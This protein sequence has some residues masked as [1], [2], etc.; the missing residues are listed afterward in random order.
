MTF[1][2]SSYI[3]TSQIISAFFALFA[4]IDPIGSIPLYIKY[5]KKIGTV[6]A[7]KITLFVAIIMISFLFTGSYIL[8]AFGISFQDFAVAG[9]LILLIL[10]LEMV[11][12]IEI[13]KIDITTLKNAFLTPVAFP[14]IVGPGVLTTL[15]TLQA[16]Y[17]LINILIALC[18]NILILYLILHYLTHIETKL[19]KT[20]IITILHKVMGIIL[21]AIAIKLFKIH[22]FQ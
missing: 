17:H 9:G 5:K 2:L 4:V 1:P 3:N 6:N 20:G 21:L 13:F 12:N 10:G 15:L 22:L 8:Q 11:L 16:D 7:F 14:V 19:S 18:L